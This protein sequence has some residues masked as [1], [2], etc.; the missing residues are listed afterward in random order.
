MK[1]SKTGL[2]LLL[3][4]AIPVLSSAQT[5]ADAGALPKAVISIHPGTLSPTGFRFDPNHRVHFSLSVPTRV[6]L[7]A[8]TQDGRRA[9]LL[10]FEEFSAG[11]HSRS[12]NTTALPDGAY[13]LL[14]RSGKLTETK[15][16][17]LTR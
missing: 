4:L 9:A 2:S 8:F 1:H 11:Q 5:A 13:F 6:K 16:I 10:F 7:E 17:L 15:R 12:L 14:L 3:A